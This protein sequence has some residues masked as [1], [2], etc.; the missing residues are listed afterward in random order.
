MLCRMH[1]TAAPPKC[2]FLHVPVQ[3]CDPPALRTSKF[4]RSPPAPRG[5]SLLFI[6][7]FVSRCFPVIVL[8]TMKFAGHPDRLCEPRAPWALIGWPGAAPR[9]RM[10]PLCLRI[11]SA[12]NGAPSAS[13]PPVRGVVIQQME[14]RGEV[15]DGMYDY[16]RISSGLHGKTLT[17]C[18]YLIAWSYFFLRPGHTYALH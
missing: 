8:R 10:S 13:C 2:L 18:R 5:L 3:Q 17:L 15:S 11:S 1:G 6:V 4:H 14:W 9:L 12:A 7:S 16:S